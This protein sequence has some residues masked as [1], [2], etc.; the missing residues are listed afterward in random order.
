M[1]IFVGFD[2]YG[3]GNI[4]D[5]LMLDGFLKGSPDLTKHRIVCIIPRDIN[6]QQFR[7]PQIQWVKQKGP[8]IR[9]DYIAESDVWLGIGDTPFQ[10]NSGFWFIHKMLSDIEITKRFQIPIY[11]VGVGGENEVKIIKHKLQDILNNIRHVWTRDTFTHD[12][13]VKELGMH[14]QNVTIGSDLANIELSKIFESTIPCNQRNYELMVDYYNEKI[15]NKDIIQLRDFIKHVAKKERV[16]FA[17]NET[18]RKGNFEWRIYNT[19]FGGF[20]SLFSRPKVA[21]YAPEYSGTS[22]KDLVIHFQNYKTVMSSRYHTILAAAWAGCRVVA[23]SRSSKINALA[24]DLDI[25]VISEP[26]TFTKFKNGYE[27][28]TCISREKLDGLKIKASLC[29]SEFWKLIAKGSLL[30]EQ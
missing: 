18:R 19:M 1:N 20:K 17:A 13:L 7:F 24:A 6:S 28:A 8:E 23:L 2:F 22:T 26:C 14:Q 29:L 9:A 5:D 4:G 16:L 27:S 12:L 3:A 10:I 11:M 30:L 15:I 21:F 25:P